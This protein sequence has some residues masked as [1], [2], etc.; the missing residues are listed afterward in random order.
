MSDIKNSSENIIQ[1]LMDAARSMTVSADD[2]K[3]NAESIITSCHTQGTKGE[4]QK[5][6]LLEKVESMKVL[7]WL[8]RSVVKRYENAAMKL[9]EGVPVDKVL[10]ELNSYNIC[11][12]DQIRSEQECYKQVLN[13]LRA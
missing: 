10:N 13:T 11:V 8:Y 12:S 2:L 7:E 5:S 6:L 3:E 9:T 4:T 1:E